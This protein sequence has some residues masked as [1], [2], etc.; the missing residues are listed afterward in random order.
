MGEMWNAL[1]TEDS[2]FSI[3]V[4]LAASIQQVEPACDPHKRLPDLLAW[5]KRRLGSPLGPSSL[6]AL[7]N[8]A[9]AFLNPVGR[10]AMNS[11]AAEFVAQG[12]MRRIGIR[13][14]PARIVPANEAP[15]LPREFL[16]KKVSVGNRLRWVGPGPLDVSPTTFPKFCLA[17]E[18][19][20][21]AMSLDFAFR[22]VLRG[23][24]SGT[25]R[26]L[27]DFSQSVAGLHKTIYDRIAQ[28][29]GKTCIEADT[30]YSEVHLSET[31]IRAMK[32]AAQWNGRQYLKLSAA[33]V[34]LGTSAAHFANVLVTGDGHLVSIDHDNTYFENGDDLEMLF[35]FVPK[36]SLVSE[37]LKE[38]ASLTEHDISA[39]VAEVPNHPACGSTEG[40]A[41]YFC[42]RFEMWKRLCGR[43]Q[44]PKPCSTDRLK[45]EEPTAV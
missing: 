7:G 9:R 23:N 39:A 5:I 14:A 21:G 31:E 41:E 13:T 19:A 1:S 35:R 15:R 37:L 16:V 33:R 17:S 24:L 43:V 11:F 34:F 30:L 26:M 2:S 12:L 42:A 27:C 45:A 44:I 8:F 10:R 28:G 18:F 29:I 40:L 25:E 4:L 6:A 38:I 22:K 36:S 20:P 32:R 3:F